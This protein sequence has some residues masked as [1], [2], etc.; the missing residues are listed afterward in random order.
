MTLQQPRNLLA[1]GLPPTA[2]NRR[3]QAP[4]TQA[5]VDWH[6][7]HRPRYP[8]TFAVGVPHTGHGIA[9]ARVRAVTITGSPPSTTSSRTSTDSPENTLS[10]RELIYPPQDND[11]GLLPGGTTDYGP[12]PND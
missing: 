12:E 11:Q 6:V 4:Y 9:T 10:I 1:E 7:R 5:A 3:G 8:C 2:Q